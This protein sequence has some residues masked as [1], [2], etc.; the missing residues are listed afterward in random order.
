MK[1]FHGI[2]EKAKEYGIAPSRLH[3]DPLVVTLSNR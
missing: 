1:V 3:I 2:M